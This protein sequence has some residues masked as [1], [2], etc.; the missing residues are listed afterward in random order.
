[1]NSMAIIV[2]HSHTSQYK[3]MTIFGDWHNSH[4]YPTL[5]RI[6]ESP[7]ILCRAMIG[8]VI[9]KNEHMATFGFVSATGQKRILQVRVAGSLNKNFRAIRGDMHL[10]SGH[11]PKHNILIAVEPHPFMTCVGCVRC[12]LFGT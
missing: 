1:M 2:Y 5:E 8:V 7:M 3:V 11:G 6:T 4:T 10:S 9:Q 12:P